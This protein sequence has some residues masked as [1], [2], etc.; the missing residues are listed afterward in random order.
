MRK[1]TISI[2]RDNETIPF[3]DESFDTIEDAISK[4]DS[5]MRSF[6]YD[7][8]ILEVVEDYRQLEKYEVNNNE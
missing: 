2:T 1:Y 3:I 7:D 5:M 4:R 8:C 6:E